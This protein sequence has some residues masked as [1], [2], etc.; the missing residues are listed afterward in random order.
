MSHCSVKSTLRSTRKGYAC[1]IT[2]VGCHCGY[3]HWVA[4]SLIYWVAVLAFSLKAAKMLTKML[5]IL[6]VVK[7]RWSINGIVN[8]MMATTLVKQALSHHHRLLTR[9]HVWQQWKNDRNRNKTKDNLGVAFY[10]WRQLLASKGM[11]FDANLARFFS[12]LLNK[13][14]NVI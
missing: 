7:A 11:M 2:V 1:G 6:T 4:E 10:H 14:Q 5:K 13:V 9:D 3:T 12:R 8:T